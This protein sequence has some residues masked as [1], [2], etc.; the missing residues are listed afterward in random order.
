MQT[1]LSL[2]GG[3][4]IYGRGSVV[5]YLHML[6]TEVNA[7]DPAIAGCGSRIIDPTISDK[8]LRRQTAVTKFQ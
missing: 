7:R 1:Q 4:K 6:Y 3:T 8:L 5:M 2:A